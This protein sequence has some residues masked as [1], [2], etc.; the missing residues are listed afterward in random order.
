M[1]AF[2]ISIERGRR[3]NTLSFSMPHKAKSQDVRSGDRGGQS[4]I[5]RGPIH[6]GKFSLRNVR[7]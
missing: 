5:P 1:I 7:T 2:N 3:A 6:P 4:T